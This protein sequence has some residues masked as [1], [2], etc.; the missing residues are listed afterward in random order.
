MSASRLV[1][2][3]SAKQ[4]RANRANAKQS[5]GPRTEQGKR[6][7][8]RNAIDHGIFLTDLLMPG[9][10]PEELEEFTTLLLA[11][12]KPQDQVEMSLCAQYVEARWRIRRVRGAEHKV[13]ARFVQGRV[14]MG[15][16]IFREE[17]QAMA[18]R[19]LE[20]MDP[21]RRALPLPKLNP[22]PVDPT[23]LTVGDTMCD[24][25]AHEDFGPFGRLARY[26]HQLELSA[27]RALRQLHKLRK[28][29]GVDASKLDASPFLSEPNDET[30]HDVSGGVA[31]ATPCSPE[32]NN[33]QNKPISDA[34]RA[35]TDGSDGCEQRT[36]NVEPLMPTRIAPRSAIGQPDDLKE[37]RDR[38]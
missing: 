17:A 4:R 10:R 34:T 6:I 11:D 18:Q 23:G 33:T 36:C 7:V 24:S 2:Y 38:T 21:E 8:A 13:H 37:V 31:S 35:A 29:R 32:H 30:H 25:S 19:A 3:V 5:T 14:S 9:E 20:R 1:K 27:D 26:Q 22:D 15:Q 28:E 16:P 12:L